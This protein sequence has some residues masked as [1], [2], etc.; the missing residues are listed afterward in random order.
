MVTHINGF[1]NSGIDIDDTISKLMKAARVPLDKLNQQKKALE[2]QRDDYR[3]LNNKVREFRDIAF[4]MKLQNSFSSKASTSS[5]DNV[6]SIS[7]SAAA[8]EGTYSLKVNRLAS[9]ASI[10]SIVKVGASSSTATLE[11][12]GLGGETTLTIGGEKGTTTINLKKSNTIA[13]LVSSVN[14]KTNIT[15]VMLSYDATLD[16][17]FFTS[18]STGS[19]AKIN[20]QMKG[21]GDNDTAN[22]LSSVLK[23]PVT[24]TVPITPISS[25]V[26]NAGQTLTGSKIFGSVTS[27]V[28]STLSSTQKLRIS[29]GTTTADIDI[30]KTT[31]I[32]KLVDSINSSE[33]GKLGVSAYV[34]SNNKIAFFNPDDSK[35]ISFSD[36]SDDGENILTALGLDSGVTQ[37]VNNIDFSQITAA[38]SQ[39]DIVFNGVS[40]NYDSN[41]FTINGMTFSA[42]KAQLPTDDAVSISVSKDIDSVYNSIKSFIDKYNEL[43]DTVNKKVTEKKY[44]DYQPLTDDQRK[45]MNDDQITAWEEK[46]KS[47]TL[48]SDSLLVQGLSN[49]RNSF[50]N[51]VQGLPTGKVKSLSEIGIS[52]SVVV[53]KAIS[54]NYTEN[55]KIYINDEKLKAALAEKPDEVM[56]LF[57]ASDG[58]NDTDK[59]DG[60]ATRLY[61]RATTLINQITSK[62]GASASVDSNYTIGKTTIGINSRIDTLQNNLELL[63]TRYYKQFTAMEKYISQMQ[64]QSAQLSQQMGG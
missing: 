35:T 11:S 63:E 25:P 27:L 31:T 38:G 51:M 4:N 15:G 60:I 49:F 9:S 43:V 8:I 12:I 26:P 64:S 19:K 33:I 29:V 17:F 61:D 47:G 53:G 62:A 44:R 30:S 57:N 52:A 24:P 42:K 23:L 54:G 13:N 46:A 20:L 32:S 48:R 40:G 55:G 59:G 37:T 50:S 34:D 7:S 2:W 14:E 28:D 10:T 5:N 3:T 1:S 36:Q 16:S 56:A 45:D 41:K 18:T 58:N 6:V 21:I 22:L 39:A